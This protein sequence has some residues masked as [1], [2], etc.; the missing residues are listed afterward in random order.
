MDMVVAHMII[1]RSKQEKTKTKE[2]IKQKKPTKSKK[3]CHHCG[4]YLPWFCV[5]Y[6]KDK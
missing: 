2:L 6:L 3:T 4:Q 1:N 5:C